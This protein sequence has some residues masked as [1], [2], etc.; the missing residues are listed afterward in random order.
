MT[1]IF[2]WLMFLANTYEVPIAGLGLV[3]L[4][5]LMTVL[6]QKEL[7]R[8]LGGQPGSNRWLGTLDLT[9]GPLTLLFTFIII[10]R[11]LIIVQPFG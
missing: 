9:I 8:A 11:L 6:I 3:V 5:L 7:W 10:L 1:L 2:T 4:L